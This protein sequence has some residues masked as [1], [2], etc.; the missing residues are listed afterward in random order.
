MASGGGGALPPLGGLSLRPAPARTGEFVTLSR[1]EADERNARGEVEP[2]THEEYVRSAEL[3][4]GDDYFRVRYTYQN[5]DHTYD[6]T[7]YDAETLWR[8]VK[9]RYT[10]PHNR[11]PIWREDWMALHDRYDPEGRVPIRVTGLPSLELAV[12]VYEGAGDQKRLV[13][14]EHHDGPVMHYEGP[15]GAEHHVRLVIQHVSDGGVLHYE[16]PRGAERMVRFEKDDGDVLYHEGPRAQERLVRAV[17]PSG[18][19]LYYEGPKDEERMVRVEFPRGDGRVQYYEG[20]PDQEHIVRIEFPNGNVEHL[21]GPFD[22]ERIVRVEYPNGKVE[23][24]EGPEGAERLVRVEYPNGNVE[25]YEG[26]KGAERLVR[27]VD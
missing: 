4:D 23:H 15:R 27:V 16:G 22:E 9:D 5:E 7:V 19:V 20:A 12:W 11:Q 21:E 26:P 8:W 25:H 6:Y 14:K 10:L 18:D 3:P 13:R 1:E 2:V 24:Y 17:E